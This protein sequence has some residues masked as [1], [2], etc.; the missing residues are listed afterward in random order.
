MIGVG[1]LL[2]VLIIIIGVEV[3]G[4]AGDVAVVGDG[5]FRGVLGV[6]TVVGG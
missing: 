3:G 2:L 6:E 1:I 5:T 4:V